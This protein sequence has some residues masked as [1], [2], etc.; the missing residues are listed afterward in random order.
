MPLMHFKS[1]RKVSGRLGRFVLGLI[2]ANKVDLGVE[3]ENGRVLVSARGVRFAN[4]SRPG[5]RKLQQGAS[6]KCNEYGN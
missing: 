4:V 6:R 2:Y 1:G 3:D 5:R